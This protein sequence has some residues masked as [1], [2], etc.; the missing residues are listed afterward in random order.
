MTLEELLAP[1]PVR[2]AAVGAI[3]G[4]LT[5]SGQCCRDRAHAIAP[6]LLEDAIAAAR[7]VAAPLP[8]APSPCRCAQSGA[9]PCTTGLRCVL[10]VR[11]C[12]RL[13]EELRHGDR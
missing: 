6:L 12:A 3:A 13:R 10:A 4:R 8:P 7:Q 1:G 11:C 2:S 9:D 5:M